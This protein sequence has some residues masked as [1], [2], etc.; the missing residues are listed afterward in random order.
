[1][2]ID[3]EYIKNH[4]AEKPPIGEFATTPYDDYDEL[5]NALIDIIPEFT[6]KLKVDSRTNRLEFST[7]INSVFDIA[8]LALARMLSEAPVPEDKGKSDNRPEGIIIRCR[9]CGK[10]I[11]RKSN[12][13]EFCDAEECQKA[14]NARKQKAYRERKAIE[15]AQKS[16]RNAH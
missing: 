4:P 6:M 10:F 5:R 7:D 16:K 12:R 13:Q 15:K 9:N 2:Q 14:R 1:M 8:W 11:I 3:N